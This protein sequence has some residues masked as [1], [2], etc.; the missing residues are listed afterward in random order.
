[1]FQHCRAMRNRI[2][3]MRLLRGPD[4][5]LAFDTFEKDTSW[6]LFKGGCLRSL[7]GA[8]IYLQQ[9]EIVISRKREDSM[10]GEHTLDQQMKKFSVTKDDL[11]ITYFSGTGAGGQYRNRHKNCV[12]IKHNDTGIIKTGQ[13]HRERAANLRDA[14]L[15]LTRDRRFLRF[16]HLQLGELE[17]GKT[18]SERVDQMMQRTEDFLVEIQTDNGWSLLP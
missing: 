5:L 13:A 12:R 16:C 9:N 18:A 7:K 8:P 2:E 11:T 15:A 14:F 4:L 1:M 6:M 10:T 17:K 3:K